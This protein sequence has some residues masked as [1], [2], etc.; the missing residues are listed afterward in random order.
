MKPLIYSI[1]LFAGTTILSTTMSEHPYQSF[2][3]S[4]Y[5]PLIFLSVIIITKFK[6][7]RFLALTVSVAIL[8]LF[9]D[10][11]WQWYTNVSIV[12]FKAL[13][14][15]RISGFMPHPND[16]AIIPLLMGFSSVWTWPFGILLVIL[17]RSRNALLGLFVT[18]LFHKRFDLRVTLTTLLV[19]GTVVLMLRPASPLGGFERLGHWFVAIKMFERA[20]ILGV[21]PYTFVD[22]YL[23]FYQSYGGE[24]PFGVKPEIGFIPWAHSLYLETIA[25]RGI[26]G[27]VTLAGILTMAWRHAERSVRVALA[28]FLVMGLFDLTLL[29]PWIMGTLWSL[30]S[31]GYKDV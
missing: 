3:R 15:R 29:K 21:G 25:E 6:L 31:L 16:M 11:I 1:W 9:S 27:F 30:I 17:S 14:D 23:P 12:G 24:L 28:T 18:I 20:P 7:W 26:L 8:L 19:V 22:N 4:G 5:T 10:A 2:L 13:S